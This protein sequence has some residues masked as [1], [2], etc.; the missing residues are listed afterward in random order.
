MPPQA[1]PS[2][3]RLFAYPLFFT[4]GSLGILTASGGT[5]QGNIVGY[6][7]Q[8]TVFTH[9]GF[10]STGPFLLQL[11]PS[12]IGGGL[13]QAPISSETLLGPLDRPGLLPIP[14]VLRGNETVRVDLTNDNGAAT[15]GV[16]LTFWGYREVPRPGQS[17]GNC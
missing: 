15:N 12:D 1:R 16:K 13:F 10:V 2:F 5:G 9:I 6:P 11:T 8:I 3:R 14:L 7:S 4:A 17:L